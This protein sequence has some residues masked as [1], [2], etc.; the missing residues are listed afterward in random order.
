M[1]QLCIIF[2]FGDT[3]EALANKFRRLINTGHAEFKRGLSNKINWNARGIRIEGARGTGKSTMMLQYIQMNLPLE[4]TLYTSLG[5]LYF[6]QNNLVEVAE[7]FYGLG[8][9]HLFLDEV[10][11]YDD[12][13]TAIKNIYDFLPEMKPVIW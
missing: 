6:R 5:D 9:R 10:H 13:Q 1:I 11:K 2:I 3:M 4:Q 7:R 12:W 8:G